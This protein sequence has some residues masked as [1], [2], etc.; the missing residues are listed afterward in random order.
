MSDM[1][2]MAHFAHANGFPSGSYK[3]LFSNL[4][5]EL[6]LFAL[7]KFAHNPKF[8]LD[9]N[10][11]NPTT[12]L[13]DYIEQN[14]DRPVVAIGHSFGGVI[15]YI[16]CCKRPDLFSG[17]IMLDPPLITGLARHV[18][19]FAKKN[20]L[21]NKI[22]PAKLTLRRKKQWHKDDDLVAY[23]SAR[24]LFK[25][26]D[27]RCIQDYIDS[28]TMLKGDE[29]KLIFDTDIESNIFRTIPHNLPD[30]YGK[31]QCPAALITARYT[32]VCVPRLRN[33]FLRANPSIQHIEFKQGAHM[34]PLEHPK[35]VAHL[36]G[37]VLADWN[38][39]NQV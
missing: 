10:W 2:L 30:Y 37:E 38:M 35:Q 14:A 28:V 34:F 11:H 23:F 12:E 31:L 1:K 17:L 7:D 5:K 33:P 13:I 22:T 39:L 36:I 4:P 3:T 26:M 21:I 29:R 15:S 18:F 24:A 8:P 25:N 32:D 19:R 20:A 9:D 27:K 6:D 16:A